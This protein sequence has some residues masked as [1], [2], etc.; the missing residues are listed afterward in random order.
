MVN[1]YIAVPIIYQV[2]RVRDGKSFATRR[3]EAIQKGKVVFSLLASFQACLTAHSYY[4][5]LNILYIKKK[6]AKN[7]EDFKIIPIC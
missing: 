4:K 5:L 6:G 3:V 1:F 7:I 2:D